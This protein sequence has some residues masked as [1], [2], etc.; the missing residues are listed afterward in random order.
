MMRVREYLAES[1]H[2][3]LGQPSVR[4]IDRID[5]IGHKHPFMTVA[6][7]S[8]QKW[9]IGES[10][11]KRHSHLKVFG[12]EHEGE[13]EEFAGRENELQQIGFIRHL[14]I[15]ERFKETE[16]HAR[17]SCQPDSTE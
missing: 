5:G 1:I 14:A 8:A 6:A 2:D 11:R 12:L 9:R 15:D 17:H 16:L 10:L 3:R 13:V 7:S 4:G